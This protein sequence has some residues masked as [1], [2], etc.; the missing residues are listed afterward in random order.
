MRLVEAVDR[1][2]REHFDAGPAKPATVNAGPPGNSG[3]KR[4]RRGGRA[5]TASGG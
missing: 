2:A 1:P 5:G 4:P 3:V